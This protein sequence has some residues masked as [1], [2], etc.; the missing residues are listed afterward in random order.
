LGHAAADIDGEVSTM[1]GLHARMLIID[2]DVAVLDELADCFTRQGFHV[3]TAVHAGDALTMLSER[4]PDLVLVAVS[5]PA[6]AEVL[7]CLRTVNP[8][9]P[10]I[11]LRDHGEPAASHA[12]RRPGVLG[13]IPKSVVQRH[14]S[15]LRKLVEQ[16]IEALEPGLRIIEPRFPVD[17]PAVDF[18]ALDARGSLVLVVVGLVADSRMFL[19]SADVYWW[20][21]EHTEVVRTLFPAARISADQPLRLLFAAQRFAR[22]FLR[23]VEELRLAD[24]RCLQ[25]LDLAAYGIAAVPFGAA[26]A[27]WARGASGPSTK[28]RTAMPEPSAALATSS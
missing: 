12:T 15:G 14:P 18:V 3:D 10:V 4:Q 5:V 7:R 27:A 13:S 21:R 28:T 9:V 24:V 8:T 16:N 17:R 20:C 2:A 25:L 19:R 6:E 22:F 26:D 1:N 11:L 23:A